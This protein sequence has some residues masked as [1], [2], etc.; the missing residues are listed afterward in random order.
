M[1]DWWAE[2]GEDK[3]SI[4]KMFLQDEKEILEGVEEFL[5]EPFPWGEESD[6]YLEDH[7][8]V[9]WQRGMMND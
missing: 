5:P 1:V 3:G 4:E 9:L 6:I 2:I 8:P 7:D